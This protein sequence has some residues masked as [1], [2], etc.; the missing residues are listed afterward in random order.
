MTALNER[1][2]MCRLLGIT[3]FN[4]AIHRDLVQRFC[5]LAREGR[6]MKGDE[7]G[8]ADGW[9]LAFYHNGDPVV[10]KSGLNILDEQDRVNALLEEAISSPV[11]ILHLRKSA[12]KDTTTTRHAHPFEYGDVV[13]AHNGTVLDYQGLIPDIGEALMSDALDTEV[14]FRHVMASRSLGL[15][16]AFLSTINKIHREHQFTALNCLFSDGKALYAYR[17]FSKEPD[18]YSLYYSTQQ[19]SVVVCSQE[20]AEGIPWTLMKKEEFLSF[21]V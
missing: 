15:A 17:D 21:H 12:W 3:H 11:F 19:G 10:Y 7:P 16:E 5:D 8:H 2:S 6:V 9:G 1:E 18:Y 4:Y 14:F 13:F 20:L